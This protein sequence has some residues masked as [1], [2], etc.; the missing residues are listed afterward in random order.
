M[1]KR[2]KRPPL[3]TT[4]RT[5]TTLTTTTKPTTKRTLMTETTTTTETTT[6]TTPTFFPTGTRPP[7]KEIKDCPK[8]TEPS[9]IRRIKERLTT[10][11]MLGIKERRRDHTVYEIEQPI[12]QVSVT[13]LINH[14]TASRT[15]RQDSWCRHTSCTRF[16]E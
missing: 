10:M 13:P 12:T 11:V 15:T 8:T 3:T 7:K 2:T 6:M 1:S 9:P 5:L 14:T 4:K 16:I